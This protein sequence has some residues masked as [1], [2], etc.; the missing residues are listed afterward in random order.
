MARL[1]EVWVVIGRR[2]QHADARHVIEVW[3]H[4]DGAEAQAARWRRQHPR[5]EVH[6]ERYTVLEP[7]SLDDPA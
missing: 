5:G 3:G 7:R 2:S 4:Q 1:T 6:V